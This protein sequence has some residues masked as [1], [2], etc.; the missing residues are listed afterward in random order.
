M[1][2]KNITFLVL[3]LVINC[4]NC[5]WGQSFYVQSYT[6]ND[7]LGSSIVLDVKQDTTGRMWFATP[8]ELR[9]MMVMNGSR[10]I[11]TTGCRR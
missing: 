3:M 6:E 7:G 1:Q 5:L 4:F 9:F 11:G 10:I 8:P 2:I